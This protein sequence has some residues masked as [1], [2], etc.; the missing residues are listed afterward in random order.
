MSDDYRLLL[1]T[2]SFSAAD[3]DSFAYVIAIM[4]VISIC[5]ATNDIATDGIYLTALDKKTQAEY[6]GWQGAFYNRLKFL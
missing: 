1:R 6:I 2:D 3:T 4:G 5:G